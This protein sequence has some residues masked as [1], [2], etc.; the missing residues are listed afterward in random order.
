MDAKV[1]AAVEKLLKHFPKKK[2]PLVSKAIRLAIDRNGAP[3]CFLI[4]RSHEDGEMGRVFCTHCGKEGTVPPLDKDF[5][6]NGVMECPHCMEEGIVLFSRYFRESSTKEFSG[7]VETFH[8][9]AD[10]DGVIGLGTRFRWMMWPKTGEIKTIDGPVEYWYFNAKTKEAEQWR[11]KYSWLF[12]EEWIKRKSGCRGQRHVHGMTGQGYTRYYIPYTVAAAEGFLGQGGLRF[13]PFNDYLRAK[14]F[15]DE[16]IPAFLGLYVKHPKQ[17]ELLMKCNLGNVV[18]YHLIEKHQLCNRICEIDPSGVCDDDLTDLPDYNDIPQTV[19]PCLK[20]KINWRCKNHKRIFQ[21]VNLT[22]QDWKFLTAEPR[23]AA[24][25]G[26]LLKLKKLEPA[27]GLAELAAELDI[28]AVCRN[29]D[30]MTVQAMGMFPSWRQ[31]I[32]YLMSQRKHWSEDWEQRVNNIANI[33][34]DYR[35]YVRDLGLDIRDTAIL[36][37]HNLRQ[38]HDNL[39]KQW[40]AER[41]AALEKKIAKTAERI[42]GL[43]FQGDKLLIRP[44]AGQKELIDEG[45]ALTHCVA[46]YSDE[47]AEGKTFILFIRR[48]CKPDKPFYTVE[49]SPSFRVLQVR[50][51]HNKG[52]T[53][54]VKKFVESY[55]SMV[56]VPMARAARRKGRKKA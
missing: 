42:K 43:M 50:G 30:E 23:E 26:L 19:M 10:D 6:H 38:A 53:A 31:G 29:F 22:K 21:G 51:D 56:P 49:I 16:L 28:A 32:K 40:K 45:K 3:D 14:G 48:K 9:S 46:T 5:K 41:N 2:P 18:A 52:A 25:I 55:T 47:Y 37:P 24:E 12:P 44:A 4:V 27:M 13:C 54:Q 39:M 1:E 8:Q 15:H 36:K 17:V 33:Y 35:K 20:I 7:Y 34:F 11:R